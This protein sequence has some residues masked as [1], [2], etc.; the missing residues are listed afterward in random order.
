VPSPTQIV[1]TSENFKTILHWQYPPMPETPHFVV[2][3]KP[4][5]LGY[6]K[7]VST[8]VNI[9]AHFCDLSGEIHELFTSHW[10]RVKA[11]VASQQ[12]EYVETDEFILQKH[13]KIGP[14]KLNLSRHGDKIMVDIYHPA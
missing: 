8:C 12:S 14:P 2:E 11:V 4:Y 1:V 10:L 6:Y 13:G 9:S 5:N 3:I 7:I